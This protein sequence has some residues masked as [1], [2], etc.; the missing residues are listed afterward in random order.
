[1]TTVSVIIPSR[2]QP[3]PSTIVSGTLCLDRAVNS[4]WRQTHRPHEVIVGLDPGALDKVPARF[5]DGGVFF[6]MASQAT[7]AHAV[8]GAASLAQGEWLAFLEDDDAWEPA[9]LA[10][11]LSVVGDRFDF[12]TSNQREVD[13]GGNFVRHNDFPTCSGWV[14]RRD[15]WKSLGGFDEDWYHCDTAFLAKANA[16]GVRRCHILE[17]GA[18]NIAPEG[19]VV[20]EAHR[21]FAWIQNVGAHSALVESTAPDSL[22]H[23]MV[24]SAGRFAAIG[25]DPA[26]GARSAAEHQEMVRRWGAVG[27]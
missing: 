2:L 21:R 16:A 27:W 23:R 25:T 11:A 22:V 18:L 12:V 26:V 15:I 8:N 9:W 7:Q 6:V 10:T 14:V 4:A 19:D 5:R 24:N 20:T 13:E 3:L 17:S 1:M